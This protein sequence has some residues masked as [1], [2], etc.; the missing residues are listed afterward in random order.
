MLERLIFR[1]KYDEKSYFPVLER[2][3][4]RLRT[5]LRMPV[6]QFVWFMAAEQNGIS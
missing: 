2:N 5:F 6:V 1:Q 4:G 3:F